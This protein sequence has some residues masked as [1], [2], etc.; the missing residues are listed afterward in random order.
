MIGIAVLVGK[1]ISA[2]DLCRA[3]GDQ[4]SDDRMTVRIIVAHYLSQR[5]LENIS[6]RNTL[7]DVQIAE[8][9][10]VHAFWL[11][12]V[13]PRAFSKLLPGFRRNP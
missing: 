3:T 5:P 11:P 8:R 1:F 10:C 13:L 7:A 9:I 6:D 4:G 2:N 12:Q